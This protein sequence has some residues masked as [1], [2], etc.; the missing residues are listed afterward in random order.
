MFPANFFDAILS[1]PTSGRDKS[2]SQI[3]NNDERLA[4]TL[5]FRL[6]YRDSS[7]LWC[8]Y[9]ERKTLKELA[10]F[11]NVSSSRIRQIIQRGIM[12]TRRHLEYVY[13]SW[14]IEEPL[15]YASYTEHLSARIASKDGVTYE[16]DISNIKE[17]QPL[18]SRW[19]VRL[20]VKGIITVEQFMKL[21]SENQYCIPGVGK[22]GREH[23][24]E[25]QKILKE[26]YGLNSPI[27]T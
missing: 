2:I 26:K 24:F 21:N 19:I 11:H 17:I 20:R 3:P 25:A 9:A 27:K 6:R 23:I 7:I 8:Y 1:P 15:T 13:K 5:I 22:I 16:T 4:T 12:M 18:L 14:P 10:D